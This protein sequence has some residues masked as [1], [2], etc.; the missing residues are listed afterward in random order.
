MSLLLTGYE[1]LRWSGR[2][3][4]EWLGQTLYAAVILGNL[5]YSFVS[6]RLMD[7]RMGSRGQRRLLVRSLWFRPLPGPVVVERWRPELQRIIDGRDDVGGFAGAAATGLA[8][9]CVYVDLGRPGTAVGL[10]VLFFVAGLLT[11]LAVHQHRHAVTLLE[12]VELR[13]A[14]EAK[15]NA[16][17]KR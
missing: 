14:W 17:E 6:I 7:R 16:V 2:S 15:Y 5:I 10:V 13:A 12:A 9:F 1:L 11:V 3:D 8:A 4:R